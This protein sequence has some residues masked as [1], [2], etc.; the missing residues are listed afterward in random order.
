MN[1]AASTT[2]RMGGFMNS[3]EVRACCDRQR[4]HT[5]LFHVLQMKQQNAA[6]FFVREWIGSVGISRAAAASAH[7][8]D[9]DWWGGSAFQSA[10]AFPGQGFQ[11]LENKE[12]RP[13][14]RVPRRLLRGFGG[15]RR[16]S[17]LVGGRLRTR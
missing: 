12:G 8:S 7:S 14:P 3:I 15:R 1:V 5:I 2:P 17:R 13:R 6:G 11:T 10:R 16:R 4:L 9:A